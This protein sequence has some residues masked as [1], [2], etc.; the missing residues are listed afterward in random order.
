[1]AYLLIALAFLGS[2]LFYSFYPRSDA[3]NLIDKPEAQALILELVA[4]HSAAVQAATVVIKPNQQNAGTE[5]NKMR[6]EVATA[7][8]PAWPKF[9]KE[10]ANANPEDEKPGLLSE[11][12]FSDRSFGLFMPDNI[13]QYNLRP[14]SLLLCVN[15]ETAMAGKICGAKRT[16]DT[17]QGTSD[18]IITIMS[19]NAI[20]SEYG[21]R[22]MAFLERALG[23]STYLTRYDHNMSA[24]LCHKNGQYVPCS[25]VETDEIKIKNKLHLT[26]NCGIVISPTT[27][28]PEYYDGLNAEFVLSNTRHQIVS[29]PRTFTNNYNV[30][31]NDII[32]KIG[33]RTHL[34]C[35]TELKLTYAGCCGENW[36][37]LNR[38]TCEAYNCEWSNTDEKCSCE[39]GPKKSACGTN[40]YG[41]DGK[42]GCVWDT[43]K[44]A[45]VSACSRYDNYTDCTTDVVAQ[46]IGCMWQP[47]SCKPGTSGCTADKVHETLGTCVGSCGN[48]MRLPKAGVQ[49]NL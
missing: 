34:L 41:L 28:I 29:L 36:D 33:D 11:E 1:M 13:R 31:G 18:F 27:S 44:N 4:Q 45:C 8:F 6:Y 25:G 40:E 21:P 32:G 26:T 38:D 46:S 16:K 24:P 15:N 39:E 37:N 22:Q 10:P 35:I 17:P 48:A 30:D 19:L 5:L 9:F 23:E 47:A 7:N 49:Q 42:Y 2:I 43:T 20:A 3:V 14:Q 12:Q